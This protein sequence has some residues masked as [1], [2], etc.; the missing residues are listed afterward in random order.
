MHRRFEF[1]GS[2][3]LQRAVSSDRSS[4]CPLLS[5]HAT[6]SGTIAADPITV[7]LPQPGIKRRGNPYSYPQIPREFRN[8][9][10]MP[11]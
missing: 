3:R 4:G 11:E 9:K 5:D 2:L 10:L 7:A 8:E 1:L 6:S